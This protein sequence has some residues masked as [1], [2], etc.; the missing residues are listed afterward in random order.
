MKKVT[1][2]ILITVFSLLA[3]IIYIAE[4]PICVLEKSNANDNSHFLRNCVQENS[5]LGDIPLTRLSLLGSHDAL[6]NDINF[7]SKPNSSED[8]IVNNGF[9]R[10]LAKGAIVRMARAQKDD[11]YYQLNSGVRYLDV[12]ICY[13]DGVY[14]NSHGLI[15]NTLETNVTKI[16]KWLSENPGEFVLFHLQ[17]HY[18]KDKTV[19]DL[20]SYMD[21]ITYEN[22]DTK[23]KKNIFDYI[24]YSTS[25]TDFKDLTYNN[26]TDNG[27]K[28]GVV[29]FADQ[30]ND[31]YPFNQLSMKKFDSHWHNESDNK[32]I[33]EK[34]RSYSKNEGKEMGDDYLRINQTQQTP[35]GSKW[36][37]IIPNWSLLHSAKDHNIDLANQTD[38]KEILDGL[39]IY[40]CD[41]STCNINGFNNKIVSLLKER[42]LSLK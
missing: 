22:P 18:L 37:L 16:L 21:T 27:T 25:F 20:K 12:R 29:F 2:I 14:Y 5:D 32:T 39:P 4:V 41:Y 8:N 11:V 10:A 34:I 3:L 17:H 31:V 15:S 38:I 6:A 23:E 30:T 9:I 33:I 36:Y 42:N 26:I 24:N 13:V 7:G 1:K 40:M 35:S 19:T 28:A